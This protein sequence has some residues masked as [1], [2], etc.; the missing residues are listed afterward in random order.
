M[1]LM[2]AMRQVLCRV[3]STAVNKIH[4]TET[5][6]T[7][8]KQFSLRQRVQVAPCVR[9]WVVAA[10]QPAIVESLRH[11]GCCDGIWVRE[12][13]GGVGGGFRTGEPRIIDSLWPAFGQADCPDTT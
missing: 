7:F 13:E 3:I 1:T 6:R 2:N 12:S 11:G 10:S 9:Q 4:A 8:E 5:C